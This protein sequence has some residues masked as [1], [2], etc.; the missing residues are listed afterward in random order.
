MRLGLTRRVT[1]VAIAALLGF[2]MALNPATTPP[3]NAAVSAAVGVKAVTVAASYAGVKYRLGG[4]S[5]TTGFDCSGYTKYVFAKIGK[6]IPRVAQDQYNAS[7]KIYTQYARAGD[8]V[9]FFSGS[10]VYHVA[11]YAGNGYIWHA[12]KPGGAVSKVKLWT[13]AVKYGRVR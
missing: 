7:T 11:I 5:P 10:R 6:T 8:L 13:S 12:P 9:F 1:G 2:G 4:T 3:A